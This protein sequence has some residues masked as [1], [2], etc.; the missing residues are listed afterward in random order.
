MLENKEVCHDH[1]SKL[2]IDDSYEGSTPKC[3]SIQQGSK[4]Q[5][6]QFKLLSTIPLRSLNDV[7]AEAIHAII[8]MST[9]A[10]RER[11]P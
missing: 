2:R 8:R 1:L 10:S 4:T 9:P 3:V 7:H 5:S 11:E 6:T